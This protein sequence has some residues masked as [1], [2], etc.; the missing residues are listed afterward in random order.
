MKQ[1]YLTEELELFKIYADDKL[2]GAGRLNLVTRY[3]DSIEEAVALSK[4]YK[5][6]EDSSD[7]KATLKI[8]G[9][10][11]DGQDTIV[12]ILTAKEIG[13][14]L[15]AGT[16]VIEYDLSF[17]SEE[18]LFKYMTGEDDYDHVYFNSRPEGESS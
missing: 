3:L 8:D 1:W 6:W 16:Y 14:A 13:P 18:D 4:K 5:D 9:K 17:S 11:H 12:G 10:D 7:L 2:I 15:E